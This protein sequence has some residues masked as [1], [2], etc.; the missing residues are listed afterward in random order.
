[1]HRIMCTERNRAQEILFSGKLELKRSIK[2]FY[3]YQEFDHCEAIEGR[4]FHFDFHGDKFI[5]QDWRKSK[6]LLR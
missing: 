6:W 5:L 3:S 1:M 4:E 2:V